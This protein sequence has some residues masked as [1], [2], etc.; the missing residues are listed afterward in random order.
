MQYIVEPTGGIGT[1]VGATSVTMN[2]FEIAIE[3]SWGNIL[4]GQG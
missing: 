2:S 4:S 1:S 3:D